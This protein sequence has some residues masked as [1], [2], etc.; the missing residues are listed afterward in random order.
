MKRSLLSDLIIDADVKLHRCAEWNA[1]AAGARFTPLR[2]QGRVLRM[3]KLQPTTR[4][5]DLADLMGVSQQ[6]LCEI[7][8]K[9]EKKGYVTR[10]ASPQ[11]RRTMMVSLT[12]AGEAASDQ[13]A[14]PEEQLIDPFECLDSSQ[15]VALQKLLSTVIAHMDQQLPER[16]PLM[17]PGRRP[18]RHAKPPHMPPEGE[19]D[20]IPMDD[21]HERPL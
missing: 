10:H 5:R 9:L 8:G 16:R 15:K 1:H 21:P 18:G 12:P 7:L 6:A 11:D 14:E 2:G 13:P 20:F 17:R 3:L 4:Q 19:D